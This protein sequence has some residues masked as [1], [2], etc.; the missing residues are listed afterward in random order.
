VSA[1]SLFFDYCIY[2]IWGL[3]LIHEA[4]LISV[5]ISVRKIPLKLILFFKGTYYDAIGP[6]RL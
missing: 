1:R 3:I 2:R 6:L 5:R 4:S